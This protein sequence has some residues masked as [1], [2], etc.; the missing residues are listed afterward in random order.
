VDVAHQ[1]Q[2]VRVFLAQNGLV[3]ILKQVPASPVP[4]VE[5]DG[6]A[7]QK[8]PHDIGNGNKPGAQQN[9]KVIGHQGP[10]KTAG[11]TV[12]QNTAKPIQKIIAVAVVPENLPALDSSDND[13]VQCSRGI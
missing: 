9:M 3:P 7:R 1:L 2:Q 6:I 11:L 12:A 5:T 4:Q 10:C 13:M 8:P